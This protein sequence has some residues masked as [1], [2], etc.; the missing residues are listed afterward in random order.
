MATPLIGNN[1]IAGSFTTNISSTTSSG[2][3][4]GYVY[5][6][7]N[8]FSAGYVYFAEISGGANYISSFGPNPLQN[9]CGT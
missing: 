9:D 5:L 8:N 3:V 4:S 1:M 7:R 6:T 2:I